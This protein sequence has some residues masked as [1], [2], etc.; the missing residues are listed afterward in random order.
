MA[1]EQKQ[2]TERTLA[3]IQADIDR[4]QRQIED[5]LA[6]LIDSVHPKAIAHRTIEDA[7]S[8]AGDQ[9]S[10][11]KAQVRDQYGWRLD[12]LALVAGAVVGVVTFLVAVRVIGNRSAKR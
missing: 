1:V 10:S 9:L 7:K 6:S 3:D 11:A 2:A 12:R 8:F 4:A 5:T